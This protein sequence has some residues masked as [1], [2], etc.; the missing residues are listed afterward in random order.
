[1][2]DQKPFVILRFL[3]RPEKGVGGVEEV[4]AAALPKDIAPPVRLTVLGNE[5]AR[6]V[7]YVTNHRAGPLMLGGIDAFFLG[8]TGVEGRAHP[9]QVSSVGAS[10]QSP[11]M[12]SHK[13]EI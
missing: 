2:L 8:L 7:T 12:H 11:N 5:A 3:T 4:R 13:L 10:I 9:L 6:E 1:M